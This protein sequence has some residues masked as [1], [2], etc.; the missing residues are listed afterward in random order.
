[1]IL[2]GDIL[3]SRDIVEEQFVCNL[4]ACKGACCVEGDFGAPLKK[5]E[6][7]LIGSLLTEIFPYLPKESQDKIKEKGYYTFNEDS[8]IFETELMENGACV[9]MGTNELGITYCGIEKAY[10]DKKIEYKK[11]ISCHLYPIRVLKNEET[12]FEAMNY[13]RW[14][15]CSSACDNGK[16]LKT[17][18]FEFAKEAIIRAYGESFYEEL[19]SA[20]KHLKEN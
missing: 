15:I 13:D 4:K 8:N 7:E 19:S 12:N 2:I 18:V 6:V 11:P 3:V 1:M 10:I 14:D 5:D 16:S 9:F 20:A 17:R